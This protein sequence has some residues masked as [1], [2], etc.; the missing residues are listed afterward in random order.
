MATNVQTALATKLQELSSTFRKK[1]SN[2]LK[3]SSSFDSSY[4]TVHDESS[5]TTELKGLE[6]R[7][8]D[9]LAASGSVPLKDSL[10][11]LDDDVQ[12]VSSMPL[13]VRKNS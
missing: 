10:M 1:Q 6:I 4:S 8:Q 7:N 5:L 2:Y 12:L 11:S 3:R 13:Y 9:I